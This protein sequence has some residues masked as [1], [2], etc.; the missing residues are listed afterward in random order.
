MKVL[1]ELPTWLGDA[2][3]TTP[4]IENLI[5]FYNGA[6]FTIV[7]SRASTQAFKNHP[8]V[9]KLIELEKN[10]YDIYKIVRDLEK[11]D[12]F[13]SFRASFRSR[14]FKLFLPFCL[15]AFIYVLLPFYICTFYFYTSVCKIKARENIRATSSDFF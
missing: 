5:D 4:A 12:A 7:G 6:Y 10:Y 3:M 14:I 8:K 13:F 2:V 9:V 11:F 15:H 1:I